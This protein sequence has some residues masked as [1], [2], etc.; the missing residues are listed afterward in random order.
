M[1]KIY[2][3]LLIL[4]LANLSINHSQAQQNLFN[5]PSGDITPKNKFFYQHQINFYQV[6]ELESK[7]HV[8]YG[9]GKGW[10]MGVN[11]VDLPLSFG[12]GGQIVSMN[13]NSNRKPLYPLL[14]FT[15]QKQVVLKEKRLFLNVGTQ[16]GPNLSNE[17]A[18]KKIGLMNYALVRWQPSKKGYLIAGPYHTNNVFVGGPPTDHFGIMFGYEY[19]L[20]DKWLLMG[21]FISGDHKKSQTI[22]GAGYNV[23]G[24]L[25]VFLGSLLAFPN[26]GLDNGVVAEIN[27][28]GWH[29]K[30]A[31]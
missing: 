24:K 3:L 31:H 16:I 18:N 2:L 28:Y 12:R 30:E 23:S 13:D 5:I 8:V 11:F 1:K 29:F 22:I 6:N 27:W 19:K 9:I 7:S 26:H 10:D 21:D 14:T 4:V 25:Q 17:L 20:N 15:L